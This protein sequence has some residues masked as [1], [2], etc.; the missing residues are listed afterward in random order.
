M[1]P[2]GMR[3]ASTRNARTKRKMKIIAATDFTNSRTASGL[4]GEEPD[5]LRSPPRAAATEFLGREAGW[6]AERFLATR[7]GVRGAGCGARAN[8]AWRKAGERH[9]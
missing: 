4:R 7:R 5:F 2:D 3:K 1:L 6:A 8:A 9:P